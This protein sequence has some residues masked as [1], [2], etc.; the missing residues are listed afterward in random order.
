MVDCCRRGHILWV[1][2]LVDNHS[3]DIFNS[4]YYFLTIAILLI[5]SSHKVSVAQ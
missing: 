4:Q 2:D 3:V 1:I 5:K